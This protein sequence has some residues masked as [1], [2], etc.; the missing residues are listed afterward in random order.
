MTNRINL[1]R[2]ST[3]N[4]ATATSPNGQPMSDNLFK[5]C[6]DIHQLI[7][8]LVGLSSVC[9]VGGTT[10]EFDTTQALKAASHALTRLNELGCRC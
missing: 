2:N 6:D 1:I 4:P 8:Q 7:H 9:W 3:G 10:G 5:E